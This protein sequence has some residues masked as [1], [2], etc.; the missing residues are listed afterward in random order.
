MRA[1]DAFVAAEL[2]GA[3]A[4]PKA[5]TLKGRLLKDRARKARGAA[6]SR[7]CLQSAKAY[8]DAAE[9][10]PDSY[11]L[12]NAATMSLFAGQAEQVDL[13]AKQVMTLLETGAG[14]GETLYWHETTKAE[15]LL[16]LGQRAEAEMALLEGVGHAP[17]AWEDHATTLRQFRSIL[18]H[19]RKPYDWLAAYAPPRSIY[20]RGIMGI[21]PDDSAAADAIAAQLGE[22]GARF[23]YGALAAG[24]DILVAEAML[25][26]GG[27]LHVVLPVM[28]SAFKAQSV[29]PYGDTWSQRFD[30]LFEQAASVEIVD[31]GDL[32]SVAA[33]ELA[34]QVAKG[35][36]VD[37]AARLESEAGLFEVVETA[38]PTGQHPNVFSVEVRRSAVTDDLPSLQTR[39]I[40]LWIATDASDLPDAIAWRNHGSIQVCRIDRPEQT[41][42]IVRPLCKANPQARIAIHAAV[43]DD[44]V[45]GDSEAARLE[46]LVRTATA[47]TAI[48]TAAA[49]M[50]IKALHPDAW[51]EPLGELPDPSG[52]LNV[53]AVGDLMA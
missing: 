1:W 41:G 38:F 52:A 23:A 12:I 53:Y 30:A 6:K 44:D 43:K 22:S 29:A 36:A 39:Q 48:A 21:A 10:R 14:V 11:P 34:A 28:P 17:E 31:K 4:D 24:G 46:R 3:T 13:L 51:I 18:Q 42:E 27:E 35:R 47:G 19:Q 15:A 5:L 8:A 45:L 26:Q 16:L 25:R 32:L 37:N 20:F 7:L 33:I 9:L 2:E 50:S 49:A 40:A